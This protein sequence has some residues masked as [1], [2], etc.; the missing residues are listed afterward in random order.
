MNSRC[1]FAQNL[2]IWSEFASLCVILCKIAQITLLNTPRSWI[3]TGDGVNNADGAQGLVMGHKPL[4]MGHVPQCPPPIPRGYGPG[5]MNNNN[6]IISALNC[7]TLGYP[8]DMSPRQ[9][10]SSRSAPS[11]LTSS[12]PLVDL[13]RSSK[14]AFIRTFCRYCHS[15]PFFCGEMLE[16]CYSARVR[17]Y[18]KLYYS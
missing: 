10:V 15:Q 1:N 8:M 16:L 13:D 5:F 4:V 12:D 6:I 9:F 7:F 17:L 14:E 11:P 18:S 3:R 2:A